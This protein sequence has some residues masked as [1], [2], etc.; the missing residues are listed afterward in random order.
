M[1][2]FG[3]AKGRAA[4]QQFRSVRPRIPRELNAAA[5]IVNAVVIGAAMLFALAVVIATAIYVF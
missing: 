3:Q 2:D 4:E 5:G 1:T